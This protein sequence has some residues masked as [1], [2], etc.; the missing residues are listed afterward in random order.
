[1]QT[2]YPDIQ[3]PYPNLQPPGPPPF[4][5]PFPPSPLGPPKYDSEFTT[6]ELSLYTKDSTVFFV[7]QELLRL[8][9]KPLADL[10]NGATFAGQLEL[11]E[12]PSRAVR[13]LLQWIY[14]TTTMQ[15]PDFGALSDAF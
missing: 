14:P 10:V 11:R 15:I 12:V 9:S 1:M 3:P 5:P 8:A 4:P 6:G 7:H 13:A 2:P